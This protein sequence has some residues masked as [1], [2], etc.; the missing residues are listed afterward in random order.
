MLSGWSFIYG[1][2]QDRSIYGRGTYIWVYEVG[3]RSCMLCSD[4]SSSRS[5]LFHWICFLFSLSPCFILQTMFRFDQDSIQ[6][7]PLSWRQNEN[8]FYSRSAQECPVAMATYTL[9]LYTRLYSH[10]FIIIDVARCRQLSRCMTYTYQ[11]T[12]LLHCLVE[13]R[14]K[15]V[16]NGVNTIAALQLMYD[17]FGQFFV[18]A[19]AWT[20]H[21]NPQQKSTST[22]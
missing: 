11:A 9:I 10:G 13:S 19:V 17:W 6:M 3:R 18:H 4:A 8:C 21:L 20:S 14:R 12:Q 1:P 16:L 15:S 5:V 22:R 2:M 7:C